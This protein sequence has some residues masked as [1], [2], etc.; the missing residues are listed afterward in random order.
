M[1]DYLKSEIYNILH[2]KSFYIFLGGALLLVNLVLLSIASIIKDPNQRQLQYYGTFLATPILAIIFAVLLSGLLTGKE[3]K[4]LKNSV[5]YGISRKDIFWAKYIVVLS[6][7]ILIYLLI[8]ISTTLIIMSVAT[9]ADF[10]LKLQIIA[11]LEILPLLI[12]ALTIVYCMNILGVNEIYTLITVLIFYGGLGKAL[13]KLSSLFDLNV[14]IF[15]FF[16]DIL[17]SNIQNLM[18]SSKSASYD[19]RAL[20]V[21]VLIIFIALTLSLKIFERKDI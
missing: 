4:I 17:I 12:S 16:P 13:I 18:E 14:K 11:A 20:W 7:F 2:K 8:L 10:D 1:K 3:L 9:S 5:A 21:S 15:N 19:Y 6:S